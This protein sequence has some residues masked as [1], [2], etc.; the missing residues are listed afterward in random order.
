[1]SEQLPA[2]IGRYRIDALIGEGG[3][4]IVYRGYDDFLDRTVAIK[5]LRSTSHPNQ[6]E[7]FAREGKYTARLVHPNIVEIFDVGIEDGRTYLVQ[8]FL[9][10]QDLSDVLQRH[11]RG[12]RPLAVAEILRQIADA[13]SHAHGRGVVHRDIKPSN[14]RLLPGGMVKV[15][16]FGIARM[17]FIGAETLTQL[18]TMLGTP[19][20]MPPEQIQGKD[21]DARAD[22][23][24]LGSLGFEL[25]T[26][27]RLFQSESEYELLYKVLDSRPTPVAEIVAGIPKGLGRLID[28]CLQKD[29]EDRPQSMEEVSATLRN[30][31]EELRSSGEEVDWIAIHAAQ[32]VAE[33][34]STINAQQL[35]GADVTITRACRSY[36]PS[37][38]LDAQTTVIHEP[39]QITRVLSNRP[40]Q[41]DSSDDLSGT[42]LGKFSLLKLVARGNSG[43]LYKAFDDVRDTLVGVK[44]IHSDNKDARDR[45]CR[46]GRIWINLA[47]KNLIKVFEVHPDYYGYPGIIVSEWINAKN[48][49]DLIAQWELKLQEKV[50]IVLQVADALTAIHMQGVVHREIMP[51]NILVHDATLHITL[52]DSGIARHAN[53]EIDAFTKTG[54]IVGDLGYCAPEQMQ[55]RLDQRSDI[56][57]LGVVLYELI[58][59]TK[60]PFP[61]PVDW[62]LSDLEL[63][64]LP[65]RLRQPLRRALHS[66]PKKRFTTVKEFADQL[67]PLV[68]DLD[69]RILSSQI[70]ATMHG[71]RTQAKWQRAFA[72]VAA[73]HG[74]HVHLDRWNFGYFSVVRFMMPWARRAKVRWFR[75]TY[76]AE[77]GNLVAGNRTTELPSIVAHSFG[78]YILGNALLRYPYLRFNKVLLCGSILPASFPWDR[79]LE[80]GQIQSVRNEFGS[81]DIWTRCVDWFVPGTGPS[82]L[83]GFRDHHE[84]LEQERF[85]FEHSE[86]FQRAHME[87]RWLPFLTS[88]IGAHLSEDI[89]VETATRERFPWGLFV[90]EGALIG[91]FAATLWWV[92]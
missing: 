86:Y 18:G 53:P 85:P 5:T 71:I 75:D 40:Q 36:R 2:K 7:R 41:Y 47:H 16:D 84:R 55:G 29:P 42:K 79:L 35:T 57:S 32:L 72:E 59:G 19:V 87:S 33:T 14:V 43:D 61:M 52:L 34:E 8:E 48:L 65:I 22:V 83:L 78:T 49:H 88:E 60:I 74:L 21:V 89:P 1:M 70:V 20:Y 51:R 26:G 50:W 80:R 92:M 23:Y 66:D 73:E 9:E 56:Y 90:I 24:A 30:D 6:N 27:G 28:R 12:L 76:Q 31:I 67:R 91:V 69:R 44:V 15:L 54:L 3:L 39:P 77:F 45:L 64:L 37:G 46:S 82:G 58:T 63:Q 10:G 81:E 38:I 25:L 17:Q 4:G 62:S 11:P 68:P 13:L